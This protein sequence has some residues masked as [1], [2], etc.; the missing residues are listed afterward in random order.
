MSPEVQ[1]WGIS[2]SIK[3]TNIPNFFLKNIFNTF[4]I[5]NFHSEA[6]VQGE[7]E[8]HDRV[9][10]LP[11]H[12]ALRGD[13]RPNPDHTVGPQQQIHQPYQQQQ[14]HGKCACVVLMCVRVCVPKVTIPVNVV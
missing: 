11:G 9:R 6:T 7:A 12:P 4:Q 1:N 8:E 2:A 10:G 5:F 13:G 14:V 3:R